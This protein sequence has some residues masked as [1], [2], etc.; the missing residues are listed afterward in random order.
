MRLSLGTLFAACAL[1]SL[2]ACI[3]GNE[4]GAKSGPVTV[5]TT[6]SPTATTQPPEP[7]GSGVAEK[8]GYRLVFRDDFDGGR[9]DR[10]KWQT[11]LPW[12]RTNKDEQEYYADS[13]VVVRDGKLTITASK[14]PSHGKQYTSG[15]VTTANSFAFK[16]GYTEMR[17]KVPAGAGYWSAFWLLTRNHQVFDEIDIVEQVGSDPH[18]AYTVLHYGTEGKRGKSLHFYRGPDFS[19]GFHTFGLDWQPGLLVWYIDGVERY[20]VTQHVPKD[21]MYLIANLTVGGPDSWSGPPNRYT[22]FPGELVIDSIRVY[23]RP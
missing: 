16:Y 20:R 3:P 9:L 2:A 6:P 21:P 12:G 1:L 15:V 13:A 14:R 18:K 11:E 19:A 10:A 22:E 4:A 17:A 7:Q 23:Q 8:L 5:I